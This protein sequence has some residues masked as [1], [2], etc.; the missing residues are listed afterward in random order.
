[1]DISSDFSE[2]KRTEKEQKIVANCRIFCVN[3]NWYA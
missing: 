1:M 2:Q 3:S